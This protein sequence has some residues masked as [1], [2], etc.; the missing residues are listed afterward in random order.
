MEFLRT[1]FH[2]ISFKYANMD[3]V[4]KFCSREMTLLRFWLYYNMFL[5]IILFLLH[6]LRINNAFKII[7]QTLDY[8]KSILKLCI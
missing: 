4:E 8:F 3:M 2:K 7:T 6:R 1:F 5:R